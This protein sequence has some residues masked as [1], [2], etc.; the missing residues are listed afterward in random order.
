MWCPRFAKAILASF[1]IQDAGKLG[2][3]CAM[4]R[5]FPRGIP[6][7][8][9]VLWVAGH[10]LRAHKS[11]LQLTVSAGF[12]R[13]A[14]DDTSGPYTEGV[15][16]GTI[17]KKSTIS[18]HPLATSNHPPQPPR[19]R[20]I[21]EAQRVWHPKSSTHPRTRHLLWS[22]LRERP[23]GRQHAASRCSHADVPRGDAPSPTKTP[24]QTPDR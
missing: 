19:L 20:S 22:R 1:T 8:L 18:L 17:R 21:H 13:L 6:H 11:P 14:G 4:A 2:W 5:R 10:R 23:S 7:D 15:I 24:A 3:A 9:R 16:I 12:L